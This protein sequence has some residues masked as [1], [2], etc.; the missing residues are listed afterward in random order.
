MN[1]KLLCTASA[2]ALSLSMSLS[3][4]AQEN[5]NQELEEDV[6]VVKGIVGELEL[7]S[8]AEASSRLG[9]SLLDTPASVDIINSQV[10]QARGYQKLSDAVGNQAGIVVGE[11]PTAPSM[12]SLRGF[13]RAQITVL[14]DGLW[15]GPA[16]MTMRQQ[17]TFNLESVEIL[18][19]PASV[20]NGN[21]A[22]AGTI[23]TVIKTA[24]ETDEHNLNALA[25]YGR[26]NSMHLG[27]G[28]GGPLADNMYYRIDASRFS[29][30]GYVDRGDSHSTNITASMLWDVTE[31]FS[32]KASV[33]YLDDEVSGYFGTPLVPMS[34]AIDPAT[35]V[36]TT[37]TGET[38]DLTTRFNNYNVE[39]AYSIA[40]QLF[41]RFDMEYQVNEN[42]RINNTVYRYQADRNWQNAEGYVYC[43]EIVGVC[44]AD[45]QGQVQRYYG[46]FILDHEQENY[47]NR[48]SIN[49]DQDFGG[50]ENKSV[51]G[52]EYSDFDFVRTRGFRRSVGQVDGD[53]VDLRKPVPGVYG[54]R[55]LRG[56]SPTGI[57]IRAL[58]AEDMIRISPAFSIVSALRYEEM[59]LRRENFNAE[60]D[61]E[62]NG[63]TRDFNWWSYRVGAVYKFDENVS[64]YGQ[65]SDAKDPVGSNI[66]LVNGNQ[67]YDLT[68]AEQ[69]EVG[70]KAV[71][72][73]GDLQT[74]FAYFDITRD[75]ILEAFNRDSAGLIGGRKSRGF[76]FST[77]MKP[78]DQLSLG[79]NAAY[80]DAEFTPGENVVAFAGNTPPNVPKWTTA[81]YIN[82]NEIAGLPVNAGASV[83]YVGERFADNANTT[84]LHGYTTVNLFLGWDV[85]DEIRVSARVDNLFD[86][87]S[88]PWSDVFYYQSVSPGFLYANELALGAPRSFGFTIQADF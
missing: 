47:G 24:K 34:V 32:F 20:L 65:Y 73:D 69:W 16:S 1:K 45:S 76:E 33:D 22:V 19:G 87:V 31:N 17:N 3:S 79:F 6:I 11:H 9:L 68:S 44:D 74:T 70:V 55:E 61:L 12:F 81:A 29:S 39:D 30:D 85:N 41:V 50:I 86:T 78:T 14:R 71:L 21:G 72:L 28:I 48:F 58:F 59:D 84:K 42:V 54:E 25:S 80:T 18:R 49:V 64:V 77:T 52:F 51:Y 40:D 66:F 36:L 57:Q 13:D 10:M 37:T 67:D 26:W 82:Y 15:I 35:D 75:D 88:I 60:G 63:F 56:S 23:N 53:S 4:I 8:S 38:I 43:S 5:N 83:R 2:V 46:Y 27:A 62:A 7:K